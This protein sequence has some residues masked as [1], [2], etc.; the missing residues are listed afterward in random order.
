MIRAH[1]SGLESS[2]VIFVSAHR[3]ISEQP[4]NRNIC[5][6]HYACA[7]TENVVQVCIGLN[8]SKRRDNDKHAI[9]NLVSEYRLLAGQINHALLAVVAPRDDGRNSKQPGRNRNQPL[10]ETRS[11]TVKCFRRQRRPDVGAIETMANDFRLG[12][13]TERIPVDSECGVAA[14]NNRAANLVA[15]EAITTVVRRDN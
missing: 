10:A 14:R 13:A 7:E 9:D 2:N 8:E 4:A 6:D 5:N 3:L 12:C 11:N 1:T 15:A